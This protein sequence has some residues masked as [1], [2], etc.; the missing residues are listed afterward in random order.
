MKKISIT[1]FALICITSL[2]KAQSH[3]TIKVNK[4]TQAT[5]KNTVFTIVEQMPVFK[6]DVTKFIVNHVKYP[7]IEQQ[8]GIQGTVYI[9][10]IVEQDGSISNV[11]VLKGVE[12]GPGL[13]AEAL[14]V[15]S[16][17]KRWEPGMQNGKKVRV[18]YNLPIRFTLN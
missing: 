2:T 15:V 1:L 5:D 17:M 8:K 18:A 11:K 12:N 3:D 4:S 16:L 13:D 14:R 10:F 6:G 9:N 7:A